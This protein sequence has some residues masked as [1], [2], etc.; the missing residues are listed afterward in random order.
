MQRARDHRSRAEVHLRD[1]GSDLVGEQ[2]PLEP[3]DG[4]KVREIDL[5][6][7]SRVVHAA[8]F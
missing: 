3:A 4:S 1:K 5:V 2:A 8:S 6:E 7:I